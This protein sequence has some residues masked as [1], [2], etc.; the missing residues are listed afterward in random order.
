M[1]AA[2]TYH[3][4][5]TRAAARLDRRNAVAMIDTGARDL[6][7]API[8]EPAAPPP[9][10]APEPAPI[11]PDEIDYILDHAADARPEALPPVY[12]RPPLFPESGQA[13]FFEAC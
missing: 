6:F 11:D 1:N 8:L 3:T 7:G 2:T 9:G 13:D 12:F 5:T 10:V 4:K